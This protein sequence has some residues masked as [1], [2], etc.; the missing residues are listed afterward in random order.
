MLA[1]TLICIVAA[2]HLDGL[3]P[4]GKSFLIETEDNVETEE[5]VERDDQGSGSGLGDKEDGVY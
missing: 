1:K 2:A 4:E 3:S 5:N